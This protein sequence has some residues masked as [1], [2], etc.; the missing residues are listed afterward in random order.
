RCLVQT[1]WQ[2]GGVRYHT[3][4]T[5]E[6]VRW[7][8]EDVFIHGAILGPGGTCATLPVVYAAVGRRLGYPLRL[9]SAWGPKWGH[10]L[11][12]W[13]DPHGERFNTDANETGVNFH[14]DD[15]YRQHGLDPADE[16]EGL[17]LKSKTPRQELAGFMAERGCCWQECGR[18]RDAT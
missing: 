13:D 15:Y 6:H 17:F 12:G 14:S 2:A 9:V 18:L 5:P 1:V 3:P 4:P 11:C 16:A 10:L 8:L 7:R